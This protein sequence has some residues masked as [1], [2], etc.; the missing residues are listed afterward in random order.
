MSRVSQ[1][2][3]GMKHLVQGARYK[4]RYIIVLCTKIKKYYSD[5]YIMY[6]TSTVVEYVA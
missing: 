1:S 6:D 2:I 4:Y 3:G 5:T